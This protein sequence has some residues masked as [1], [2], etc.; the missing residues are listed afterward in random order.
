MIHRLLLICLSAPFVWANQQPIVSAIEFKGHLITKDYII[1]REIQHP[2]DVPL[3]SAVARM[4]R[5]RIYNL[6]IFSDVTWRAIPLEDLTVILEFKVIE[7][8]LRILPG[9]GPVYEEDYGWSFGGMLRINNFRGRN[10]KFMLGGST[11]ARRAY[12]FTFNNPWI[13]GDHVSLD[14]K[15]GKSITAHPFLPYERNVTSAEINLGRYFGYNHK[16]RVGFE[17]EKKTFSNVEDTLEYYY[18]APQGSYIYDTRDIYRDPSK[19][20]LIVQGFYSYVEFDSDKQNLWWSQ[21]YSF[22]HSL[23]KRKRKLTAAFNVSYLTAFGDVDEVWISWLGGMKTVRGWSIPN[24]T[25]YTNV[26]FSYRFGNHFAI[27]STE[28]RQTIIP[29][30]VFTTDLFNWKQEYGLSAIAFVDVGFINRERKK[31]FDELPMAGIGFGFRIPAP[32]IGTIGLDYGWGYRDGE[33]IDQV[34]HLVIGQKF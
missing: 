14:V 21:S 12:F 32:M 11:G 5:E 15:Y 34:L 16:A 8:S 3:D 25:I 4:D 26:D 18:I 23:D 30:S 7:T 22:Y 6:G 20:I 10:E 2:I 17:W 31:L 24:S 13:A 33:F 29:T 19:G 27:I 1:E 9:G 28:L